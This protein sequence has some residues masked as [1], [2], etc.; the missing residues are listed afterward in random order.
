MYISSGEQCTSKLDLSKKRKF[1]Q[2]EHGNSNLPLP[3]HRVL[4]Q[5]D[6]SDHHHPQL[7]EIVD[8]ENSTAHVIDRGTDDTGAVESENGSNISSNIIGG[9]DS[10]TT[11]QADSN[12]ESSY[13]IDITEFDSSLHDLYNEK[14]DVAPFSLAS[15]GWS[16]EQEARK[17]SADKLT[18]DQEFAQYFSGFMR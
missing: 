2:F 1:P 3:K 18:I 5:S 13:S 7:A 10:K 4:N 6:S 9:P 11:S 15:G 8:D 12:T 14:D 16:F 17:S